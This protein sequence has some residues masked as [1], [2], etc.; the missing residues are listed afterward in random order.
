[1]EETAKFCGKLS[2]TSSHGELGFEIVVFLNIPPLF[3]IVGLFHGCF[4]PVLSNSTSV[5]LESFDPSIVFKL[6][7]ELKVTICVAG[8]PSSYIAM[9]NHPEFSKI[10]FNSEN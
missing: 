6:F 1:M 3:H 10:D 7:Q 5:L 9:L 2:S 4:Q 8:A